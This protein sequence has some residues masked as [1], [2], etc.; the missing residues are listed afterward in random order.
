MVSHPESWMGRDVNPSSKSY[1]ETRRRREEDSAAVSHDSE[2]Q[3]LRE[4]E[5]RIEDAEKMEDSGEE[6]TDEKHLQLKSDR[7]EKFEN[8]SYADLSEDDFEP[9]QQQN[10]SEQE[11]T[12]LDQRYQMSSWFT[13]RSEHNPKKLSNLGHRQ[14]HDQFIPKRTVRGVLS[15]QSL[16]SNMSNVSNVSLPVAPLNDPSRATLP[17]SCPSPMRGFNKS[18]VPSF[19]LPPTF[20]RS[21]SM[22]GGRGKFVCFILTLVLF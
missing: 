21:P 15:S 20:S 18:N 14:F 12:R 16:V 2:D 5:E 19:H 3:R 17:T 22:R 11:T 13:S 9:T 1:Y 8:D 10:E 6:I 7:L 4:S